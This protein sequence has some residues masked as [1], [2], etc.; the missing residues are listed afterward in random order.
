LR[1]F[2]LFLDF[3]RR[4]PPRSSLLGGAGAVKEGALLLFEGAGTE[5]AVAAEGA[6][7]LLESAENEKPVAVLLFE[8]ARARP[9]DGRDGSSTGSTKPGR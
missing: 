9:E 7:L 2:L 8:G 5:E 6:A 4:P 3:L 1:L